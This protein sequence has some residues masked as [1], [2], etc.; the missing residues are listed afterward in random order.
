MENKGWDEIIQHYKKA[1]D[2]FWLPK[3]SKTWHRDDEN[4]YF[5]LWTAYHMAQEC[6]EKNHLWYAR[7]LYMMLSEFKGRFSNSYVNYQKLHKYAIPMME[8][9]SLAVEEGNPPTEKEFEIG[10]LYYESL[11]YDEQCH[12]DESNGSDE[13][14]Q[15]IENGELLKDFYYTD[16]VPILFQH[17]KTSAILKLEN[18]QEVA[19]LEF[20]G[21]YEINVDC[22]PYSNWVEELFCYPSSSLKGNF[23]HIIFEVEGY[24]ITCEHIKALSVER[25][26]ESKE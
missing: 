4:G 11:L 8:E 7:I 14:F 18:D 20:T 24:R 12:S 19:T 6:E 3:D 10:K 17:T 22:D 9:F 1:R 15:L 23:N 5:H 21:L 26:E 13:A 16:S 2:C 25:V